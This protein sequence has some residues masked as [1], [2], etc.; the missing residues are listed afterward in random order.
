MILGAPE[1]DELDVDV[2]GFEDPELDVV[3]FGA[4]IGEVGV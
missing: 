3:D 1:S 2:L 4:A